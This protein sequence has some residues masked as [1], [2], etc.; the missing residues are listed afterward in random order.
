MQNFAHFLAGIGKNMFICSKIRLFN[1]P[2]GE[3]TQF[4]WTQTG[5]S[6]FKQGMLVVL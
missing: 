3:T 6:K 1:L 4:L 2:I 5:V